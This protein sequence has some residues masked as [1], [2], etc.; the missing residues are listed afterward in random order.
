MEYSLDI[1]KKQEDIKNILY[2]S[3]IVPTNNNSYRT[4]VGFEMND[5]QYLED[6]V[7]F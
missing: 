1:M 4:D 5:A 6:T 3:D 7:D 2:Q